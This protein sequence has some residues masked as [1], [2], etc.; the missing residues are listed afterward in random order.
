MDADESAT[1]D[2]DEMAAASDEDEERDG[3][4]DG[5][6]TCHL[7]LPLLMDRTVEASQLNAI[8]TPVPSIA[9]HGW[10]EYG[11]SPS[12]DFN[13][14]ASA[15]SSSEAAFGKSLLFARNRMQAR[16]NSS[17]ASKS[18]SSRLT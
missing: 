7:S 13:A 6:D 14:N 5:R 3:A 15:I 11:L 16:S 1:E 4:A 12:A 18:M 17:S 8:G 9:T 2:A 10:M